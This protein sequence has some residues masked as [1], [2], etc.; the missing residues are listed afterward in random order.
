MSSEA[1]VA[2]HYTR[3]G[4]EE[5][6]M[7]A[8]ARMGLEPDRLN[9]MDLAP[10]DEFHVGGLD[11][12]RELAAQM[13]LASGLRILE[14]G[15]GIGG[16]ARYFAAEHQCKVTGVD[17]TEEFVQVARS[18]TRQTKLDHLVEF[19]EGSALDLPFDP[20]SFDRAYMIHVGMNIADKAGVFR[21]VRRVLKPGGIFAIF[22]ILRAEDGPIS[23]PVPWASSE[24]T[25]FVVDKGNYRNAL[26]KAGF[27]VE[28][29]RARTAFAIEFTERA[30]ARAAQAGQPA[31]ALHL[32]MGNQAPVMIKNVL[33]M[34]KQGL[35]EPVEFFARAV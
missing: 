4:L 10:A 31:L 34:M 22:D 21:E 3:G 11:A 25:S 16:P 30:I 9:A 33:A 8:V 12:T 13:D 17:L 23:Y 27:R 7:Q 18:L 35:L 14:V 19:V 32:L 26:E 1:K 20:E 5:T 24:E 28:R 6:I 2:G 15:S 29:E